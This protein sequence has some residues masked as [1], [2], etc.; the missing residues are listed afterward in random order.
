[1]LETATPVVVTEV[2][3]AVAEHA[4]FSSVSLHVIGKKSLSNSQIRSIFSRVF[5]CQDVSINTVENV[6]VLLH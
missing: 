3:G 4:F 6:S 1:V 2:P 5:L